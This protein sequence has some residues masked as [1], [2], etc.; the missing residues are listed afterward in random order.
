MARR[1]ALLGL[2]DVAQ[3]EVIANFTAFGG[4]RFKW[5]WK[6][7]HDWIPDMDNGGAGMEIL[8]LML[9]Q[10]DGKRI[11]LLPAWPTNWSAD[12]KLLAPNRTTIQGKVSA[13]KITD[14]HVTPAERQKDVIVV[15]PEFTP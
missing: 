9:M 2:S 1:P 6:P 13:G 5:F 11:Q 8:Q 10:C 12:F 15:T 4:Q 7:G 14:L 3:H